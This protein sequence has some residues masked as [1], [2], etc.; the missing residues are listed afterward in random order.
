SSSG[1]TISPSEETTKFCLDSKAAR[2]PFGFERQDFFI[3]TNDDNLIPAKHLIRAFRSSV[4]SGVRRRLYRDDP[5][6]ADFPPSPALLRS[7]AKENIGHSIS[8]K[9][10]Q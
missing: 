6:P 2:L 3:S 9:Q 1:V 4:S 7:P 5:E 8:Q 10:A